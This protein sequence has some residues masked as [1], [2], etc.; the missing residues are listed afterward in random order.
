MRAQWADRPF[1]WHIYP[2]DENLHHVKLRAFLEK[3]AGHLDGLADFSRHWNGA[4]AGQADWPALWA[5]LQA[6]LPAISARAAQ[7]Q[8]AMVAHGD[9][10]GNLLSFAR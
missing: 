5:A 7:W 8:A 10:V 2:Q 6:E 1:V 4:G 3:Y 9:L